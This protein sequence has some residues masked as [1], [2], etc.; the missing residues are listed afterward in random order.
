MCRIEMGELFIIM[1]I[2]VRYLKRKKYVFCV[3][4]QKIIR[5]HYEKVEEKNMKYFYVNN[6]SPSGIPGSFTVSEAEAKNLKDPETN[7]LYRN[8]LELLK[9]KVNE[10]NV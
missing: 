1:R 3:F 8:Q 7:P 9:I 6:N 4:I 5:G 2:L 10:E